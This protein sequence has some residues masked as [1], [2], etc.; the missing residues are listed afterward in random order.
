MVLDPGLVEPVIECG[1]ARAIFDLSQ[2]EH[3]QTARMRV[4]YCS[5]TGGCWVVIP[6]LVLGTGVVSCMYLVF[7]NLGSNT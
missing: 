7:R 1:L 2:V 3:Q 5:G 4:M 6:R